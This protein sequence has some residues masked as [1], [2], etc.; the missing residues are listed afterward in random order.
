[1]QAAKFQAR[2]LLPKDVKM[3]KLSFKLCLQHDPMGVSLLA[4]TDNMSLAVRISS[5]YSLAAQCR[6]SQQDFVFKAFMD[7]QCL[8]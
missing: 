7:Q 6:S 4:G 8:L 5:Q 3:K 1:M 2:H